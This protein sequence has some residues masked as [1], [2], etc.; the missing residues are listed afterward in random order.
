MVLLAC[1]YIHD[2]LEDV[3]CKT[4]NYLCQG[5]EFALALSTCGSWALDRCTSSAYEA[6]A[7]SLL[8]GY[9]LEKGFSVN[10]SLLSATRPASTTQD[11]ASALTPSPATGAFTVTVTQTV[12]TTVAVSSASS[13]SNCGTRYWSEHWLILWSLIRLITSI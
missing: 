4:N 10:T 13:F 12:A 5:P 1:N 6:S 8:V 3:G 2:V 11:S 9:C 7:S